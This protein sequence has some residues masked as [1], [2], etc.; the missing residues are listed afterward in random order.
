M[1]AN[2]YY[3]NNSHKQKS[4]FYC[5]LHAASKIISIA[6]IRCS[7]KYFGTKILLAYFYFWHCIL[8]CVLIEVKLIDAIASRLRA[9]LLFYYKFLKL[10]QICQSNL[11]FQLAK[12]SLHIRLLV[13]TTE[14]FFIFLRR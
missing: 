4:S 9:Q 13:K 14:C 3:E 12:A 8:H 10:S 2:Y 7:L 5:S 11:K 1:I 6:S